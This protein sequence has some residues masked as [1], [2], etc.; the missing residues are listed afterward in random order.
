MEP[1][2]PKCLGNLHNSR[3][4]VSIALFFVAYAEQEV[5]EMGAHLDTRTLGAAGSEKPATASA[6]YKRLYTRLQAHADN[7]TTHAAEF[8]DQVLC[9]KFR[10]VCLRRQHT[11]V[12]VL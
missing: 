7:G 1:L 8:G 12:G 4:V 2:L 10:H 5:A 9:C 3:F 11:I 6:F